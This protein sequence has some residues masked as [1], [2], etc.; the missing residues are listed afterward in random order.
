MTDKLTVGDCREGGYCVRGIRECCKAFD[1]DFKT[2]LR[3]GLDLETARTFD[4]ANVKRC[5]A[6]ADRRIAEDG[7]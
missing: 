3:E 1:V 2:F 4:D 5:V 6:I 7:R